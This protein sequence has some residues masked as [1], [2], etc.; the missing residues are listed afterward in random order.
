[1]QNRAI[2]N[3]SEFVKSPPKLEDTQSMTGDR[4]VIDYENDR[5]SKKKRKSWVL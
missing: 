5:S 1:M 3:N 2:L 4:R